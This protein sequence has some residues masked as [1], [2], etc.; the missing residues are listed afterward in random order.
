MET[1]SETT[2]LSS[3]TSRNRQ[4]IVPE[5]LELYLES[6][7][8]PRIHGA[9]ALRQLWQMQSI[10]MLSH[11]F[12]VLDHMA[13][14]VSDESTQV[15][16]GTTY[17]KPCLVLTRSEATL[18]SSSS[19]QTPSVEIETDISKIICEH[20]YK[21]YIFTHQVEKREERIARPVVSGD[22][23]QTASDIIQWV[24]QPKNSNALVRKLRGKRKQAL[25]VC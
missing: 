11:I 16:Q 15:I 19:P 5:R 3:D 25:M 13:I 24:V 22:P 21:Y 7:K 12:E 18:A 23:H 9:S 2:S 17:S 4:W 10:L 14:Y 6:Q 8:D 20:F 1:S